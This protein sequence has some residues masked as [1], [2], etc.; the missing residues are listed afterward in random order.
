[1]PRTRSSGPA[2]R[3]GSRRSESSDRRLAVIIPTL[4]EAE[5]LP[6]LLSD[7]AAQTEVSLQLIVSDG[8]SKDGTAAIAR[9][10]GTLVLHAGRG[11]GRQ[12]NAGAGVAESGWLLF[13]HADSRLPARDQLARA[14]N[15]MACA[16]SAVQAGH[17][18]LRFDRSQPGRENFFRH[19]EA[20]S[21]SNR[22]G[23]VHGDQGLLIARR[24][25]EALGGF[26]ESLPF[27]EDLRLA[28]RIEA[29]GHWLLLPGT[30]HTSARRF[31]SEGHRQRYL[32]MALM[33]IAEHAGL[34][35]WLAA[36]PSLYRAQTETRTLALRP[37]LGSLSAALRALPADRERAAQQALAKLLRD[38]LWQLPLLADGLLRQ[39]PPGPLLRLWDRH[40]AGRLRHPALDRRFA[41]VVAALSAAATLAGTTSNRKDS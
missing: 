2:S 28:R 14:L 24:R 36:V 27:L 12:L 35:S 33:V 21:A 19:L 25:F 26:D 38:N 6:A 29:A 1:M 10:H 3:A 31:E 30:L 37:F 34:D 39:P 8:G 16:G 20:K 22:P 15:A 11:R 41:D 17:W 40:L 5:T 23:T 4:D 7:L 32:L 9:S 13:L 18:P